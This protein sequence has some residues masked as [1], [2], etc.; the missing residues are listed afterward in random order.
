MLILTLVLV[1]LL[2]II[3]KR[4]KQ[5]TIFKRLHI[6]GPRPN[7]IFGNLFDIKRE[8]LNALCP[9]WTKKYGPMVGF[10]FG[11][12]PQLMLTDLELIRRV[13]V[14]DFHKFSD[15]SQCIPV[16]TYENSRPEV[17]IISDS[18]DDRVVFILFQCYKI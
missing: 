2:V 8:G 13:L 18:F 1:L 11:G 14:K 10:Y 17:L 3:H 6:P 15:R 16:N 4:Q 7:F 9:K 5:L 12:R